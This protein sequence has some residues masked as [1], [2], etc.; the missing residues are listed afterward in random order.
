LLISITADCP[1]IVLTNTGETRMTAIIHSGWKGTRL[2]IA[3]KVINEISKINPEDIVAG[4]Y[5]GICEKCYEVGENFSE[6]FPGQVI[7]GRLDLSKIIK[8]Q[9]YDAG[10]TRIKELKY[11]SM[12]SKKLDYVFNSFRRDKTEKRNAVFIAP[13]KLS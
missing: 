10:V 11:C 9:L 12:H 7:S 6:H 1:T 13:H 5:P 3:A 8:S 2:G 4:I